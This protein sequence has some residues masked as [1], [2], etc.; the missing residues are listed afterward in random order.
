MTNNKTFFL[1][2]TSDIRDTLRKLT[3]SGMEVSKSDDGTYQV[4]SNATGAIMFP[5]ATRQD[6][7]RMIVCMNYVS[8]K[9]SIDI[10][11]KFKYTAPVHG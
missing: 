10:K 1:V 2:A 6:L 11:Q 8:V 4:K 9:H 5:Q 7:D 3:N